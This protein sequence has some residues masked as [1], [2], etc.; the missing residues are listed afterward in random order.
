MEVGNIKAFI[1]L[2]IFQLGID[3]FYAFPE[4]ERI[5]GKYELENII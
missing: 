2:L 4:A 1:Y 5:G 3:L